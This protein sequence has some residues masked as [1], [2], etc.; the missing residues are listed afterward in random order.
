MNLFLVDCKENYW[1]FVRQLGSNP[2]TQNGFFSKVSITPKDQIKYMKNNFQKYKICLYNNIPVGYIGAPDNEHIV[3]CVSP[4]F[5]GKGIGTYLVEN[6]C[7]KYKNLKAKV[8]FDNVASQ[9]VFEKLKFKKEKNG[10]DYI[11][12]T[13]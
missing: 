5:Q 13:Q 12:Y 3:Y 2:L 1:E 10:K 4:K 6:F 9:K 7:K 8:K 11:C